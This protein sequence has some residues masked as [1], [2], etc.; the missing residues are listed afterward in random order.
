M[1]FSLKKKTQTR[2]SFRFGTVLTQLF[3]SEFTKFINC[4][5]LL[6]FSLFFKDVLFGFFNIEMYFIIN[7]LLLLAKFHI[8]HSKFTHQSPL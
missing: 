3:S 8:H 2:F 4:K 6:G 1:I 7:F 5:V